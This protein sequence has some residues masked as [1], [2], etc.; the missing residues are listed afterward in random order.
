MGAVAVAGGKDVAVAGSQG[1]IDRDPCSSV[2]H[3]GVFQLQYGEITGSSCRD[4]EPLSGQ[5]FA[6]IGLGNDGSVLLPSPRVQ[7]IG[8]GRGVC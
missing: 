3:T 1:L 5:R 7:A 4:K 6:V 2:L 8:G